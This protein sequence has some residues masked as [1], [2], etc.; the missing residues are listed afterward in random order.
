MHVFGRLLLSL[1][2]GCGIVV[3]A[4]PAASAAPA[5]CADA[6][7]AALR[8]FFDGAL[9]D[10]LH[11]NNVPGAVVSV[12]SGGTTA[13]AKGYGLADAEHRVP[14]DPAHSLVRIAS[15]TK[16]FTW[17]AVMQQVEAGR[18]DLRADVNEYLTD[19]R[20][21]ETFPEPVTLEALMSHTA[22]F[23]ERVIGTAARSADDVPDLGEYLASNMPAR[24]RPPGEISAYSNYGA[25]LAG[26][27]VTKV[28]GESYP[29]Y[30]R[31][32]VF[33]PLGMAHSTAAEP[34][35]TGLARSYD[36]DTNPPTRIPFAFDI[37]APD[38]SVSATAD[39]MARFMLA[40]LRQGRGI[41]GEQTA[42]RMHERSFAADPRLGGWAHGFMD[43]TVNGHRVL[44]HDGSWEG[45][46]SALVLVPDCDLGL[47]VST[48]GTGGIDALTDL[49]PEFYD[50]FVPATGTPE[51]VAQSAS[52]ATGPQA[53]FYEPARHNESTV[54][55]LT[56]LLGPSRLTVGDDGTVRF[57]GKDW[58]P[59]GEGL[60]R[61]ADGTDRLVFLT[62]SDGRR[63]VATDGTAFQ[64]LDRPETLPFNL[65]VLLVFAVPAVTA[66]AV[67]LIGGLRR[68]RHRPTATSTR[69]RLA[70]GLAAG[71]ALL[72]VGFLI[73]LAA[74]V[75]G[76][77]HEFIFGAP[78]SL[79]LLLAIPIVVLVAATAALACTVTGWR[80]SGAGVVARVHQVTLLVGVA[81]LIWFLWQWNLVGWQYA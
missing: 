14:F 37:M 31:R 3:T 27:L 64:L 55:K 69:W 23:E 2:T 34:P 7:P 26:H 18:L 72:G 60:Y 76:G 4:S 68:L 57:Q 49:M 35:P 52:R 17:T 59:Q 45:F 30:L 38:G 20:V 51:P 15:I 43:R 36:S 16:L 66:L 54:E 80:G 13:F 24:I 73:G 63:Y 56:T 62:G 22:G 9:P 58:L 19:F 77:S 39:D 11:D 42:A 67:P 44:M 65:I 8:E 46:Q 41:L 6:T 79:H 70:R 50:R 21:P 32:H 5:G 25:A 47:F 1:L 29:D 78:M 74:I 61:L 28:S 71:A 10:R 53:G 40:H 33:D 12:V 81:A 75:I 48:N